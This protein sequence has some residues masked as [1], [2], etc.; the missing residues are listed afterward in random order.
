MGSYTYYEGVSKCSRDG[1]EQHT[2]ADS[3]REIKKVLKRAFTPEIADIFKGQL[4]EGLE[5]ADTS[6][7][8]ADVKM[9]FSV[10]NGE[11][12]AGFKF[13]FTPGSRR[14]DNALDI[15]DQYCEGQIVDG[16]GENTF[17]GKGTDGK[18]F[19]FCFL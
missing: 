15:I 17:V 8:I 2:D 9:S 14:N 7:R 10:N 4:N 11:L 19:W 12:F 6:V 13:I 5:N 1:Y 16:F 3:W 18:D